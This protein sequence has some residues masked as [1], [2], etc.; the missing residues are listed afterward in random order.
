MITLFVLIGSSSNLV[1]KTCVKSQTSLNYG[2][3]YP[4]SLEL[5]ALKAFLGM[6]ALRWTIVA[7][8]ATCYDNSD[9][10][11]I[12]EPLITELPHDK[13]NKITCVPSEDSDQPEHPGSLFCPHEEALGPW[14]PIKRISKTDQNGWMPKLI[15]VFAGCTDYFVGFVMLWLNFSLCSSVLKSNKY[16]THGSGK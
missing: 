8:W 5:P 4:F 14:L 9:A 16:I 6:L 7:H 12:C 3:I 13:T 15:Q 2:H 1:T 11:V 10:R